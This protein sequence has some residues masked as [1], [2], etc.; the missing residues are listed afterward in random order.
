MGSECKEHLQLHAG[1]GAGGGGLSP[2]QQ[3]LQAGAIAPF[4]AKTFHMV[5]DSATDA[6][7]RWGGA[8]NTFLVLD[9]AA[10]SDYLLPSYFKHRNFASF[11]RQ[12]N[13]YGFRK[14]DTDRWEFAHESFLRGQ[15]HLLPLIVRKKKKAGG[16]GRELCEEGEEV[17]GTIRDV[18]RLREEQRGMEEELQAMDRRLRAAESRPGQMMAFLAKLADD[19]GVVLRAMLAKKEELAAGKGLPPTPL[20]VEAPGKRRRIGGAEAAG[21]AGEAAAAELA[22]GRGAVPFPFSVLGQVFY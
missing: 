17:R 8:S 16:G 12:L 14:V 21:G 9:P 18:R 1:F 5:S 7:V 6:V 10:F 4:V 22:Q 20:P 11:V 13:T 2:P 15:A 3:Q 19:P